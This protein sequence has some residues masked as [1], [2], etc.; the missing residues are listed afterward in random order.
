MKPV[1]T[2][3]VE[4][5]K[6][7]AAAAIPACPDW[8]FDGKEARK[9]QAAVGL[10]P[11]LELDLGNGA[12][13]RLVLVP[14]GAFVMGSR[15]GAPDEGPPGLVRIERP[16]YLGVTEVTR[17]QFNS[18]DPAHHNG[19]HDQNHKDHTTPGYPANGP[20]RPVIRISWQQARAFCAWLGE[21]SGLRCDL[22]TE[23]EWEWAC[24]AGT[25][26]PFSYGDLDTDF[27]PFANLADLATKRLAVTGV[28]PQPIK[29]PS[30][31]EDWLP[32]DARFDD[33]Q[34]LMCDVGRYQPNAW[35]LHDMHGNVCEWTRSD[36]RP[37]PYPADG[38]HESLD[39]GV[40]KVVRGGS[41]HGRP[42]RARSSWRWGYRSYQPVYDVG[43]RVA[44]YPSS[45]GRWGK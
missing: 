5:T 27:S 15:E 10:P 38:A 19:Y 21:R 20:K 14:A 26:T 11:E 4:P 34:R 36:Y 6:A 8:P 39:L 16:F 32:K 40:P 18:F 3:F 44:V 23:A 45:D 9:R 25:A 43:F 30:P 24:R 31:Y 28:N 41:W 29:N 13:L 37:Y 2:A 42:K 1:P 12:A 33:G 35:G 17:S 22:P 7:P